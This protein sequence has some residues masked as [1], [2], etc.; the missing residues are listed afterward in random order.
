ME[1]REGL[2]KKLDKMDEMEEVKHSPL[3]SVMPALVA[4][5]SA[6]MQDEQH[7]QD[8]RNELQ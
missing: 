2:R 5:D 4:E 8:D 7:S 1:E 6:S 3:I